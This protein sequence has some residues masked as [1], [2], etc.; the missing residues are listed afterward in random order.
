MVGE[1]S[2]VFSSKLS[3]RGFARLLGAGAGAALLA[4]G[5]AS[6]GWEER[7]AS[8]AQG[9]LEPV[10]LLPKDPTNLILL[11]SNENPYG[12]SP[13]ALEA[14]VEAHSVAMRYPD[15]WADQLREMLATHHRIDPETVVVTCGSQELLKLAAQAFLGPGKRLVVAGPTF[16]AIVYYGRQTGAEVVKV[17][18]TPDYH[19][20]LEAMAD[21]ARQRPGL[22]YLCNPNNPTGIVEPHQRVERFLREIPSESVVLA[23]EAYLHYADAPDYKP[24]LAQVKAGRNVVVAR[25]FSKIYGMAGLRLGYGLAR[26]ELM[27]QMRPH[28]VTESWNIMACAAA[29]ASLKDREWVTLNQKRN[30]AARDF[31]VEAMRQRGRQVIPS[32][33]NFVCI[34]IPTPVHSAIEEF[35]QEG[36]SIGRL[37]AGLPTHIR[38]SIGTPE[39]MEKFVRAYDKLFASGR[40][41]PSDRA[42]ARPQAPG[43][44]PGSA[45]LWARI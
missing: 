14:M 42:R 25:T 38:V 43:E 15:Y 12:P 22:V 8:R 36:I 1:K 30:R 33:T 3:R 21:A 16:E 29:L 34:N 35:R 41:H 7:M 2:A 11:N 37:F 13:T 32:Q 45:P 18:V 5:V 10:K 27:V 24:L 26:R 17:P 44:L 31:L 20:D 28:Q 23:D 40:L 19:H 39:E 6:R 9:H 4:P